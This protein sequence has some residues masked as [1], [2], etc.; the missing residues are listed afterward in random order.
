MVFGVVIFDGGFDELSLSVLSLFE[1]LKNKV[2]IDEWF[3][4]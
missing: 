1:L 4:G 3:V 2:N